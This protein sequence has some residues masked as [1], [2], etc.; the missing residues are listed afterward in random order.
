M[1]A[2]LHTLMFGG[3]PLERVAPVARDSGYTGV[4]LMC[5]P[6]HLDLENPG[7]SGRAGSRVL[8]DAG[9]QV[10]GLASGLG[11]P[12]AFTG[13]PGRKPNWTACDVPWKLPMPLAPVCCGS[14]VGPTACR[15]TTRT[16]WPPPRPGT[17]AP[18]QWPPR[19]RARH[20]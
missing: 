16:T 15:L 20:H 1:R 10:V 7:P 2:A 3:Y 9:L 13:R 6:P 5:R 8:S 17:A 14:G 11:R 18:P 19:R 12:T 4:A